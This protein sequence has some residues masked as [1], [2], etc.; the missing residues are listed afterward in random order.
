MTRSNVRRGAV[1]AVAAA[2]AIALGLGVAAPASAEPTP[3]GTTV[4]LLSITDFHG[5][6]RTAPNIA[7]QVADFRLANRD[8][9]FSSVGDS[10]GGSTFESAIDAD[11]PTIQALNDAGLQVSAVGNHEFDQGFDDLVD[12]VVP[13]ADFPYLAANVEGQTDLDGVEIITT[14]NDV[15]VA[16]IG[17]VTQQTP[18]I[19]S[20]SGVAGL[21]FTDPVAVTNQI[22]DQLV[23]TDQADVIVALA[24]EG[25]GVVASGFNTNVDVAF[26][27]HSHEENV[28][29][30]PNG[31]TVVQSS[32]S[33]ARL[34]HV[35]L[36]VAED[37]TV[38]V[39]TAENRSVT[40]LTQRQADGLDP[41]GAGFEPT[42]T[43][44]VRAAFD[45]ARP[46][47]AEVIGELGAPF[48][49]PSPTGQPNSG[50]PQHRGSES[51]L[52][53][54]IAEIAYL[55]ANDGGLGADFG[56][57]NPGGIRA[58]LVPNAD[59]D[60]T[61]R[62]AF[63]VTSFS[64][65]I[66]TLDL[67]GA[68]VDLMLE[69]QFLGQGSRPV[70]AL[71]LS[72]QLSYLYDPTAPIGDRVT[73]VF[74][75]G[76][77]VDTEATY[78]VASN[79][80]LLEGQDG[81]TVFDSGTNPQALAAGT[82]DWE[83]T[84]DFFRDRLAAGEEPLVP[85]YLQQSV[86]L[87]EVTSLDQV[88]APG[89]EI[90]VD[91]S[92][93][94]FT[95]TEPKPAEVVATVGGLT[96]PATAGETLPGTTAG[97]LVVPAAAPGTVLA[98]VPVDNAIT[99]TGTCAPNPATGLVEGNDNEMGRASVTIAVPADTEDGPFSVRYAWSADGQFTQFIELTVNVAA[100]VAPPTEE[101]S[102]S[103]TAPTPTT[104]PTAPPVAGGGQGEL[105][106]TGAELA[107]PAVALAALLLALGLGLVLRRRRTV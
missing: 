51:P 50:T 72:P 21:T 96:L 86:G 11:E 24:H 12:R 19:V 92:S 105:P 60:I 15:R 4:D 71:G 81:F 83:A 95:S 66:G 23:L 7:Q 47:G 8:T 64:N 31:V 41:I 76:A 52:S 100:D 46:I 75:N 28:Q 69:Q 93:L 61:F 84:A 88:F 106:Q 2:G 49:A 44:T 98:T 26:T 89:D 40:S 48:L 91:L 77:P 87:H 14:F 34:G 5:A 97:D 103:P 70:L 35:A 32:S 59:G 36:T 56:I 38:T 10:I 13:L 85:T 99:C 29:T 54:L 78:T 3:A 73:D 63:N 68:Q 17:T 22:A 16:Y 82:I 79:V 90:T 42:T 53:N 102:P 25:S 33:G 58:D 67:T 101:P 6:L 30:T 37:G 45:Y 107:G 65:L 27:G 1:S 43:A 62:Q 18:S 104:P 20:E 74:V 9:V 55:T 80:F 57:I 39:Q 94:S